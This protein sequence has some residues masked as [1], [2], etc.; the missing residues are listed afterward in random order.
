[1]I[2]LIVA[3]LHRVPE[4]DRLL[5]SLEEQSCRDFEVIVVDQ[6]PDNRLVPVLSRHPRLRIEHLRSER[7]LSRARNVGLQAASGD[8]VAIPDDDCWYP[9][10]LLSS[11]VEWF[12][13]HP[14]F[15]LLSTALH[16]AEYKSSGPNLP[17]ASCRCTK[18]NVW[19]CAISTAMFMQRTVTT[20]IGRFNEDIGV[21]A[22]SA[23]QSGEETDYVLRALEQGFE[24]W[25]ES[26]LTVHHPSLDSIE[27]LRK[28]TYPFALGAGC[29]LRMHDYPL[30][31]LGA[32][33]IRSLGGAAV[34][35]CQGNLAK[36]QVYVLR[37]AGQLVGY[38]SAPRDLGRG[39]LP[40]GK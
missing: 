2:S 13:S 16:N 24:M 18:S 5:A 31:E 35:L 32:H 27:R 38:V 3:T 19:R 23:Y 15:G 1:M 21:G 8:L 34:S 33:V 4:L 12:A 37:G 36:A 28:T 40:T 6:N 25:Y 22:R 30:H 7:G 14:D 9:R 10:N 26:S 17:P 11:V 29:V 20:A 39:A